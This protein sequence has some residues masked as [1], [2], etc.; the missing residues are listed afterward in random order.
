[1]NTS[2]KINFKHVNIDYRIL[3]KYRS[4]DLRKNQINI[5]LN[6]D[7]NIYKYNNILNIHT[8]IYIY[9]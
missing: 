6:L 3:Q 4:I 5:R 9:I 7:I 2:I 1:M 8:D